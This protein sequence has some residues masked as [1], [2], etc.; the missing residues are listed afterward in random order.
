MSNH[1]LKVCYINKIYHSTKS[2]KRNPGTFNLE[3]MESQQRMLL[4]KLAGEKEKIRKSRKKRMFGS[5]I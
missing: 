2:N 5:A 1:V 3:E 4:T